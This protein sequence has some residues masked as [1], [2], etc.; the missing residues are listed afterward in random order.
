MQQPIDPLKAEDL[1]YAINGRLQEAYPAEETMH[2]TSQGPLTSS[3]RKLVDYSPTNNLKQFEKEQKQKPTR[4]PHCGKMSLYNNKGISKK[5]G[6]PY[7][8]VKCSNKDCGFLEWKTMDY[9]D[10]SRAAKAMNE[11]SILEEANQQR[12]EF[13]QEFR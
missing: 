7:E 4:C 11:D 8:N 13:P 6:A 9:Y 1:A 5:S 2:F 12:D 10:K 3:E